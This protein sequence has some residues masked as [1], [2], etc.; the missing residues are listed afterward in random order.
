M[1]A[2]KAFL[3]KAMKD[4][5]IPA[6][7]TLDAYAASHRAVADLKEN[8]ELPKRVRVRTSKYLNNTIEQ[9]HRR[10]K[11]RLRPMLGLK[12][13]QTA[14]VVIS[15]ID[16]GDLAQRFDVLIFADDGVTSA[17]QPLKRF[18]QEGGTILAIGGSTSLAYRLELP[19]SDALAQALPDGR[20]NKLPATEFYVPGSVLQAKV[21]NANPL[22]FGMPERADFFFENSPAFRVPRDAE[23]KGVKVVAWYDSSTPLRSGWAWGQKYLENTAAVVE[24]SVGKGKLFLFGPE[25]LFRSQPHGTYK[26]LFN[27]IYYGRAETVNLN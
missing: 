11:Q 15:G 19:I 20:I 24:A 25:I 2:A 9:D 23:K 16:A 8:G 10:V 5:R 12:S 27:G 22:A 17:T 26:F 21:D 3:R 14:A 7:I 6:K 18:L 13:F 4:E 1:N